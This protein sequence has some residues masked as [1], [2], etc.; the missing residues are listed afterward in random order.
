[1][2]RVR[3]LERGTCDGCGSSGGKHWEGC[4]CDECMKR[5]NAAFPEKLDP[6]FQKG[7]KK[8]L[9]RP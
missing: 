9:G 3:P 7:G 2:K 6:E 8:Y 1:M 5:V 4:L